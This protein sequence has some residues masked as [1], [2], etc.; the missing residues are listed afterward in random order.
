MNTENNPDEKDHQIYYTTD[1]KKLLIRIEI[2][3][4]YINDKPL[5]KIILGYFPLKF[6]II[7][8]VFYIYLFNDAKI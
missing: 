8:Y 2:L 3:G 1:N 7:C 6:W 4:E 5:E